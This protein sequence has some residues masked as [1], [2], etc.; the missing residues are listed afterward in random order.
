MAF[1]LLLFPYKRTISKEDHKPACIFFINTCIMQKSLTVLVF[2]LCCIVV[3]GSAQNKKTTTRATRV[4]KTVVKTPEPDRVDTVEMKITINQQSFSESIIGR[5]N[6]LSV[7]KQ[8]KDE[9]TLLPGGLMIE[10][11]ADNTFSGFG[12]C[13][14]FG[15]KYDATG[16]TLLCSDIVSTK[17]SCTQEMLEKIVLKQLS[18]IKLFGTVNYAHLGLKDGTG[19]TLIECERITE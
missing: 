4:K 19:V 12:G 1:L 5:W 15:G 13:N 18:Q 16:A 6:I 17:K 11:K 3:T 10:F 8:Q 14:N 9:P 7:R 2:L